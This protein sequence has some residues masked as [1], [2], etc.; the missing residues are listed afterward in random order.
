MT[1][2]IARP[3][4]VIWIA[5]RKLRRLIR[6]NFAVPSGVIGTWTKWFVAEDVP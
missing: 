1:R 2:V 3:V 6:V 5:L 4:V